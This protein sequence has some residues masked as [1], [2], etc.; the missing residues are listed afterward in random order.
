VGVVISKRQV[1]RLRTARV[2]TFQSEDTQ[3]LN[4]GLNSAAVVLGLTGRKPSNHAPWVLGGYFY[5]LT[6]LNF[7]LTSQN[8]W[9]FQRLRVVQPPRIERGTS[10]STI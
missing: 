8:V 7:S 6:Y 1:V 3:A 9:F 2:A 4:A 5:G 10:R